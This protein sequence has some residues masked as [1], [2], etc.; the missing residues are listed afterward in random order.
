VNPPSVAVAAEPPQKSPVREPSVGAGLVPERVSDVPLEAAPA[1]P[2]GVMRRRV[3]DV[4]ATTA[5]TLG[6]VALLLGSW[7]AL[8]LY[9]GGDLPT[10]LATAITLMAL[11]ADPLNPDRNSLGI[12][13]QLWESMQRVGVG[14][15]LG[16]LIAVPIGVLM[17]ASPVAS[18]LLN[19]IAQILR[20]V[21]PLVWFPLALVA[22]KAVG[23][24]AT[25]TYFTILITSL[26]PTVIST[27][28]GVSSLPQD[29]RT[30]ARVFEFTRDRYLLRILL[31]HSLPHILTGLRVSMGI[32]WLVIV[33]T[34]MLSG[35][36]GIGF[37]AWDS[38]NAGSY[39]K[40][41]AAVV[42]I[43]VVGLVLDQAFSILLRRAQHS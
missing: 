2:S 28:F 40:M 36:A 7:Q 22:F 12:G 21:S 14:F 1:F 18:R 37:F 43:G 19:P 34:E 8:C 23:G 32:A 20:P 26:W 16:S 5:W 41:V 35:G 33:A 42:I 30:V 17:G 15:L 24:T 10:P 31:P 13:L 11:L 25:A 27:A 29:Y 38:Y 39:E 9:V 6:S 4:A 3:K